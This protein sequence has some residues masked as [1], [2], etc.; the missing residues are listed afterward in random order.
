MK[1]KHCEKFQILPNF[2]KIV[3]PMMSVRLDRS[4]PSENGIVTSVVKASSLLERLGVTFDCCSKFEGKSWNG[5]CFKGSVL[6][7]RFYFWHSR[8]KR[9]IRTG[10]VSCT[11][12]FCTSG[13]CENAASI[14]NI[15]CSPCELLWVWR[16]QEFQ[17]HLQ[18]RLHKCIEW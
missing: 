15:T 9:V 10:I 14:L 7:S 16:F 1:K 3:R 18:K 12:A 5:R 8:S 2:C 17:P 11:R 4:S 13:F 6:F